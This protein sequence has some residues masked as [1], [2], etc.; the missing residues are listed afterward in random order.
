MRSM[1]WLIHI[2]LLLGLFFGALNVAHQIG[3]TF[4]KL[5]RE[6]NHVEHN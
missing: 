3:Y 5:Q 6:Q 2:P 1:H 4:H